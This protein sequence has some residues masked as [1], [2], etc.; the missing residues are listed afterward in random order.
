MKVTCHY[1]FINLYRHSI[2]GELYDISIS[3]NVYTITSL[4]ELSL[5]V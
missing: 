5:Q 3:T 4:L 2:I 1:A